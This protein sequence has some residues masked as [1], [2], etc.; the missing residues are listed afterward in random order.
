VAKKST[1]PKTI[2]K[3]SASI[4]ERLKL[5]NRTQAF[6]VLAT[7]DAGRPYTSLIAFALSPD[8]TKVLFATPKTTR[9]Y[10]NILKGKH[11]ALLIDDRSRKEKTLLQ[12]EALT[13]VG[14]AAPIKRGKARDELAALFVRKHPA[15]KE[16]VQS[17]TTALISVAIKECVHVSQFQTVSVWRVEDKENSQGEP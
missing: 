9:K 6:A 14:V 4:P 7:E 15:L 17:S 8:L 1:I 3:G 5:L 10:R 11:V 2:S 12:A 13:I 16:F